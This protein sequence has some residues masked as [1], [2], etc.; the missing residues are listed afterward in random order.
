VRCSA[1]TS[2]FLVAAKYLRAAT[3]EIP[4]LEYVKGRP[5]STREQ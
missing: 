1:L 4:V 3:L 5:E 2:A